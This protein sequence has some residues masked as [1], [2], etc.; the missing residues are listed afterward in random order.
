[1]NIGDR[2]VFNID[3]RKKPVI[4]TIRAFNKRG[5]ARCDDGDPANNDL[6]SNGF[7]VSS[8]VPLSELEVVK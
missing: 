6:T 1:M 3:G 4:G 2:V 8:W 7:R 5:E